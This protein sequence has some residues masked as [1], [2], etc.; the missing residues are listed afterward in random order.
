[1]PQTS[2]APTWSREEGQMLIE[3]PMLTD[4]QVREAARL[5]RRVAAGLEYLATG[6]IPTP[7][8]GMGLNLLAGIHDE[9]EQLYELLGGKR[10]A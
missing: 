1:M 3:G 6:G 10:D 4:A 9:T 2:E 5:A 8:S 7:Q